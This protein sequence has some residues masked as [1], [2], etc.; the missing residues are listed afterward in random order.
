MGN[1]EIWLDIVS[2]IAIGY[3]G[4]LVYTKNTKNWTNRL[5]G[6]L[7]L[8]LNIYII[9]NYISLHPPIQTGLSQ[10]FWIRAVMFISSFI[11]PILFVLSYNFPNAKIYLP[12]KILISLITIASAS[13]I[14]SITPLVF[15]SL[16]FRDGEPV[17]QPGIGIFIFILDFLGL[18]IAS[19][20][21]LFLKYKN[22]SGTEKIRHLYLLIGVSVSFIFMAIFTLLLVLVF[23]TSTGVFAGPIIPLVLVGLMFYAITKHN[24]FNIRIL[25]TELFTLLIWIIFSV[26][27]FTSKGFNEYLFNI[28]LL[29]LLILFGLFLIR[30]TVRE[31]KELERLSAAKSEFVSIASHQLR[32]PLTAIKGFL[33]L[34]KEGT[35][36]QD[37]RRDW[38]DK[39]YQSNERLI[40]LVNDLL[41]ISRIERGKLNYDFKPTNLEKL[42]E[43]LVSELSIPAKKKNIKLK[44]DAPSEPI[45]PITAD[46]E[47][48]RQVVLN[49]VDNS[50]NYTQQGTVTIRIVYLAHLNRIQIIVKDTGVGMTKEDLNNLFNVFSRG[51]NVSKTHVEGL[52]LG[53]YLAGKIVQAHRGK[54]WA[55]SEGYNKGSTF[56]I[57]LPVE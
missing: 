45:P 16:E 50:I 54:I 4:I 47:K 18:V 30:G 46:V 28:L 37:E 51:K 48:L 11:G 5:F 19:I 24:L 17:P 53:L 26:N 23:K 39:A 52:G 43:D 57:E 38:L 13:I 25:A 12:K 32:T 35:G 41:N 3:L 22:A 55:T 44:W 14:S 31:I 15:K 20:V 29:I 2:F 6:L 42:I 21:V 56:Y 27:T 34:I 33:S 9:I 40:R 10:L 49:I 7:A 36:N 8:V 1:F